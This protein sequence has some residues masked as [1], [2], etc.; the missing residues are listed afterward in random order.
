[1]N[2]YFLFANP[3][4]LSGMSRVLDLGSTLNEYNSTFE[5]R[6]ADYYALKSDWTVVGS[7]LQASIKI[8]FDKRTLII[9]FI[10]HFDVGHEMVII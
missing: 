3:D 10:P 6:I 7:D 5:P 2:D 9:A 4:F 1:M 8:Q